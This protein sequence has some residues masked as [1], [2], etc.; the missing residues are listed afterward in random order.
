MKVITQNKK[1]FFDYNFSEKIEAGVVLTGDEVKSIRAGHV[2]LMGSFAHVRDGQLFLLNCNITP[3]QKAY[4][5]KEEEASRSRKLLL[6]KR[7]INRLIGDLSKKGITIV[8]LRIYIN[9]KG[10]VI[11][12]GR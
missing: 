1:A 8:P 3:Y 12:G 6:H 4:I 2:S 9:D 10:K 7:E 5:K 11:C